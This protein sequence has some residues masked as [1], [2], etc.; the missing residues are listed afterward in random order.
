MGA[1]ILTIQ[2]PWE[3]LSK[4]VL[5]I[6]STPG[7]RAVWAP[8]ILKMWMK[9]TISVKKQPKL[10]KDVQK[11][12]HTTAIQPQVVACNDKHSPAEQ[13]GSEELKNNQVP[14]VSWVT[15]GNLF[16]FSVFHCF[17][18]RMEIIVVPTSQV[19]LRMKLVDTHEWAEQSLEHNCSGSTSCCMFKNSSQPQPS[20]LWHGSN[21]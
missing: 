5:N 9:Q 4:H 15:L 18:C 12:K 6:S 8:G 10:D 17:I 3:F 2:N 14:V 11:C 1:W 7:H 19:W 13:L 20:H 16:N 21:N